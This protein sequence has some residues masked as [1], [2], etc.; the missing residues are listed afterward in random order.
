M[1]HGNTSDTVT[2]KL[3]SRLDLIK[4]MKTAYKD[5][6]LDRIDDFI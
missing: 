6:M 3:K 2:E 4:A 5:P 1:N